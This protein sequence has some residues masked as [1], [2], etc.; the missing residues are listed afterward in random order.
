MFKAEI[1]AEAVMGMN[2]AA[3]VRPH[4]GNIMDTKQFPVAFFASFSIVLNAL[5]NLSTI[6]LEILY[7]FL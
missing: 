1:A 6:N 7:L 2:A 5:D 4:V 3:S